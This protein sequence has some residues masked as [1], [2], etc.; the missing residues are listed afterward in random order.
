MQVSYP[1]FNI[2][3]HYL[4]IVKNGKK[5]KQTKVDNFKNKIK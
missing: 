5:N 2:Q 1:Q 3:K 4:K